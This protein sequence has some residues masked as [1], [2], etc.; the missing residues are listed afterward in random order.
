[1]QDPALRC[2]VDELK[3]VGV[4]EQ[5]YF[6]LCPVPLHQSCLVCDGFILGTL[7][8]QALDTPQQSLYIVQLVFYLAYC[9][10]RNL[11]EALSLT[12]ILIRS[13]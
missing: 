6:L 10:Q 1:M 12:I 3:R 8:S 7:L 11:Y 13:A 5:Y 9:G 2:L 4:K